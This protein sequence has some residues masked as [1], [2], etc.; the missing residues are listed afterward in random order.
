MV[1]LFELSVISADSTKA[2]WR[3]LEMSENLP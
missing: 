3:L 1:L 2:A